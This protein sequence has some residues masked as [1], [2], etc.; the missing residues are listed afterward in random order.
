LLTCHPR[1]REWLAHKHCIDRDR[2]FQSDW[3]RHLLGLSEGASQGP[4]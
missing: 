2:L 4:C 3:Y 1:I